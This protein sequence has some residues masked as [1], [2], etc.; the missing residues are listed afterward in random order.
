MKTSIQAFFTILRLL[1][2][3]NFVIILDV[4][5]KEKNIVIIYLLNI[6]SYKGVHKYILHY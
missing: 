2:L 5:S 4:K 1:C 6:P 3:H